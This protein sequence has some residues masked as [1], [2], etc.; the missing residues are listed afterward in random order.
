[1]NHKHLPAKT[2]KPNNNDK[3]NIQKTLNEAN[4]SDFYY[5]LKDEKGKKINIFRF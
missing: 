5:K 3:S 1:M 4:G 2:Y